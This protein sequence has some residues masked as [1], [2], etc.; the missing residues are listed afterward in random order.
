VLHTRDV[1]FLDDQRFP[2]YVLCETAVVVVRTELG[3]LATL[4]FGYALIGLLD[5]IAP[6]GRKNLAG[7]K[8]EIKG[9]HI[10]FHARVDGKVKCDE[11]D[12][13]KPII[14]RTLFQG[15]E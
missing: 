4:K 3:A 8:M 12:I 13:S 2:Y 14:E 11:L 10:I 1:D 6:S 5:H 15:P 7:L 9:P